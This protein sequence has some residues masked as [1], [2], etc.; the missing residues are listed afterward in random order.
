MRILKNHQ[1]ILS[2]LA[3]LIFV[4]IGYANTTD[5][6]NK[7]NSQEQEQEGRRKSDQTMIRPD[8]ETGAQQI[9]QDQDIEEEPESAT[10]RSS[11]TIYSPIDKVDSVKEEESVSKY[12]FIFYFL[13]KFKY[14]GEESP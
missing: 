5:N 11:Q 6:K 7:A 8:G 12:N 4:N 10:S 3:L 1:Y 13:Y 14:D 9:D 2:T